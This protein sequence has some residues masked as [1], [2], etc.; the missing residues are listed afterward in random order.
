[1]S[2][3]SMHLI[4]C[5][6]ATTIDFVKSHH[7]TVTTA[8]WHTNSHTHI[9]SSEGLAIFYHL[10]QVALAHVRAE[11]SSERSEVAHLYPR[12]VCLTRPSDSDLDIFELVTAVHFASGK[13]K[14][15]VLVRNFGPAVVIVRARDGVGVHRIV[16]V[17]N[18]CPPIMFKFKV[19]PCL[20]EH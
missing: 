11:G 19:C 17:S 14:T 8:Q 9:H 10:L 7:S 2:T 5:R 16:P 15:E 3:V 13:H 1:M 20:T 12:Y 6:N 18:E 4:T